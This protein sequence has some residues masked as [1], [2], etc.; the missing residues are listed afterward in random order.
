M[1]IILRLD[2]EFS[3]DVRSCSRAA[4]SYFNPLQF[5]IAF[6]ELDTLQ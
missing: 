6:L 2:S 4:G 3:Q 5:H 1:Q